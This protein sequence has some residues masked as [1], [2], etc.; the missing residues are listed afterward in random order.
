MSAKNKNPKTTFSEKALKTLS[1]LT[2]GYLLPFIQVCVAIAA[3][4]VLLGLASK[5][6]AQYLQGMSDS[7]R[8]IAA[9]AVV[10]LLTYA[11]VTGIRRIVIK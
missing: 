7:Q 8:E 11:I 4:V 1:K 3:A 2:K 9:V 5:G 6:A 10:V